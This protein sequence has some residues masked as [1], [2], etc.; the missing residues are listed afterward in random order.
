MATERRRVPWWVRRLELDPARAYRD[1]IQWLAR[2]LL[3][4][5]LD[6]REHPPTVG[7]PL[8]HAAGP[9]APGAR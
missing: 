3:R 8:R 2:T 6:R 4:P 5:A 9:A 1:H 7:L